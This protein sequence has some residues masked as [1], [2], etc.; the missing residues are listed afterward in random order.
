MAH[1][2]EAEMAHSEEAPRA[3]APEGKEDHGSCSLIPG[4]P[5]NLTVTEIL[6][7]LPLWNVDHLRS[8]NSYWRD[9]VQ[10]SLQHVLRIRASRGLTQ[11][12]LLLC[13]LPSY[14]DAIEVKRTQAGAQEL[15]LV[16]LDII[17]GAQ[18]FLPKILMTGFS[19]FIHTQGCKIFVLTDMNEDLDFSETTVPYLHVFNL[20]NNQ[21]RQ[22]KIQNRSQCTMEFWEDS[23]Y[24]AD[25]YL[26]TVR[27]RYV[28]RLNIGGCSIETRSKCPEIDADSIEWEKMPLLTTERFGATIRVVD[29]KLYVLG[30][31]FIQDE[32]FEEI[33][34]GEVLELDGIAKEWS[35]VPELYPQ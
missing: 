34:S 18:I 26:F 24:A 21:W 32:V 15:E 33:F 25:G 3:P 7:R 14:S 20:L 9:T 22:C 30:G 2:P 6:P 29:E 31:F 17:H 35:L 10:S 27:K 12:F 16:I 4:L 11:L 8:V 23:W 28:N 5:D 1:S 19:Y 13:K